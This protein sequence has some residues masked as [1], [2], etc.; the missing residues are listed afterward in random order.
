MMNKL[1]EIST[2]RTPM[3]G[4][5][6]IW[7]I[8]YHIGLE[9][10][11][12]NPMIGKITSLG[13]GGVDFFLFLSGFGLYY[14]YLKDNNLKSFYRKRFRRILPEFILVTILFGL[15]DTNSS[16]V[17]ILMK[18]TTIGY[19]FPLLNIP[20]HLWY[21]SAIILFYLLFPLYMRFFNK[22]PRLS[23]VTG[24]I[25]GLVLTLIYSYTFLVLYP[26]EK[27][28]LIFFTSRI[29]LFC[30]GVYFG[31]LSKY[32]PRGTDKTK[33]L[34]AMIVWLSILFSIVL[35][36]LTK[37]ADYW[38]LRNGGLF[39]YPFIFIVPGACLMISYVLKEVPLITRF[40]SF[41][42]KISFELYLVHE[43]LIHYSEILMKD[44]KIPDF[45]ITILIIIVSIIFAYIVYFINKIF[46]SY[47]N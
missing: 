25:I 9:Y 16:I 13:Y 40:L 47:F 7:V 28:G 6:I 35:L 14:S 4:L 8:F 19:W 44:M 17:D 32:P 26:H 41:F 21:V 12:A 45:I 24:C 15:V 34:I 31:R 30:I 39:F 29:P 27:N 43:E 33:K 2:Y 42:G 1:K 3:M 46:L 23:L 37:Y 10:D 18:I 5:S 20:H 36:L 11:F 38:I 22:K